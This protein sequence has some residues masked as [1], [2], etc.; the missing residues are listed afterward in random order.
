MKCAII[1]YSK[2]HQNTK[3]L[4][5]KIKEKY[6]DITLIDATKEDKA[7]LKEY[8]LIGFASGIYFSKLHS[9]VLDFAE[10]NLPPNKAVFLLYTAGS[11]NQ[12]YI[13]SIKPIIENKKC[14]L[15]GVYSSFGY[16]TF[17][18]FKLIGGLRK[19]HPNEEEL[20]GVVKFFEALL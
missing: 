6:K 16:D 17:G 19:G 18:P 5:D 8:D 10:N 14:S 20:Q 11:K 12:K 15:K 4:I 3:K 1:Y 2:H 13:N 9:S 7:D